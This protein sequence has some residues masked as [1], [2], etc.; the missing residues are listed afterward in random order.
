MTEPLF[1]IDEIDPGSPDSDLSVYTDEDL[2]DPSD[3]GVGK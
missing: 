3:C 2:A 1:E